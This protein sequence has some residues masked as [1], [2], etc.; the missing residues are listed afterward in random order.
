MTCNKCLHFEMDDEPKHHR[1]GRKYIFCYLHRCAFDRKQ[2]NADKASC[3]RF[4]DR[5]QHQIAAD[6][7]R[8]GFDKPVEPTSGA[9][10]GSLL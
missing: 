6:R 3:E 10:Q 8:Y 7:K 1:I 2:M 9:A 4:E 5:Y